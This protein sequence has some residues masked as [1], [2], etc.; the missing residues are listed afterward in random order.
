M[1]QAS[2]VRVKFERVTEDEW[3]DAD[4][5]SPAEIASALRSLRWVNRLFGGNRMHRRLLLRSASG[6]SRNGDLQLMEVASGR[7]DVLQAAVR[8]L[9]WP[10]ERLHITLLDRSAQHLP[11]ADEGWGSSLPRPERLT[12]DAL[13]I[14]LPDN[15]VDI[16]S[17]C[18]F[19]HHL[20]EAGVAE[21]LREA[22]RVARVAVV[23]ND[24]ERHWLHYRLACLMS[25]ADPSRLSRHD[26]PVS[27]RQ[28]YT[29]DELAEFATAMGHR[30]ELYRGYLFRLGLIVWK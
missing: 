13:D 6:V 20:S 15:S 24:L 10:K 25:V 1:P 11:T 18:L 22:L 29:R 5:G 28:A 16:V 21:Y 17:N 30:F 12:A 8:H 27:V 2:L 7:A 14:P 9:L 23:V 4:L 3:L 19:L 26:G